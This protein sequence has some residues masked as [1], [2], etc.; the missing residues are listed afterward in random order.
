MRCVKDV[1]D[2]P[3]VSTLSAV[4]VIFR[5]GLSPI[6]LASA[7]KDYHDHRVQSSGRGKVGRIGGSGGVDR[8]APLAK[9]LLCAEGYDEKGVTEETLLATRFLASSMSHGGSVSK[10]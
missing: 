4:P 7:C 9:D 10:K 6:D 8:D 1:E 2:V 5:G 3:N